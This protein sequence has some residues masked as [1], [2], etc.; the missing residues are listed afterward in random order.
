MEDIT[1]SV[2]EG[3]Q[4]L[5]I[6]R[7]ASRLSWGI[8]VPGDETQTIYVWLDALVNYLTF[9]KYPFPPGQE[10]KF[11]WPP[12]VHVIGKD[13]IRYAVLPYMIFFPLTFSNCLGSF[14]CVYWPAFL[15]ALDLP[16]PRRVLVHGH[17]TVNREKMSKSTGN[18]VN[19]FFAIDRFGVDTMR[20]FLTYRG[21]LSGDANY[22]NLYIT[23]DYK[24]LLQSGLGNLAH[25]I[26]G[27]A[28]GALRS[29]V[30]AAVSGDLP[31]ATEVDRQLESELSQIPTKVAEKM[32]NL[33]PRAALQEIVIFVSNVSGRNVNTDIYVPADPS[34][35]S[36][37][38][39]PKILP[40][41][42]A[43]DR[44]RRGQT[45]NLQRLRVAPHSS[46]SPPALHARQVPRASGHAWGRHVGP[47]EA[48]LPGCRLW[49]GSRLR[50]DVEDGNALSAS[51]C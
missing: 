51:H 6:S 15:M 13:I 21:A 11:G 47:V 32:D 26:I 16:L 48:E 19:P 25:R 35:L 29:F 36:L 24:K 28:K 23:R 30:E 43:M 31:P 4:D 37:I 1:K 9:A 34:S 27:C 20:F 33:D 39:G 22:D 40:R 12:D 18:S 3:L 2:S 41:H 14:H 10:S 17:W 7:P 45:S 38:L 46:H 5:S 42:A 49:R 8:R 50:Q 44:H